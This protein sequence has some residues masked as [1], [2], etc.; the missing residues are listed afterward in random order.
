MIYLFSVISVIYLIAVLI[1]IKRIIRNKTFSK[2]QLT[3][4]CIMTVILPIIWIP[5]ISV[6]SKQDPSI[7]EMKEMRD[8]D[9]KDLHWKDI[10][11]EG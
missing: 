2:T 11:P 5:L 9:K 7:I 1:T 10:P 4:I 6:M 8:F 3:I